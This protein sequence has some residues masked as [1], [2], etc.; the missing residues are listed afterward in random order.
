LVVNR[1]DKQLIFRKEESMAAK[2]LIRRRAD[3]EKSGQ[4]LSLIAR[5]RTLAMEQEGYVSGETLRSAADPDEYLVISSWNS[6]DD[7]RQW[8]ASPKR[9]EIQKQIDAILGKETTYEEFYFPERVP[10]NL[11]RFKGWEGG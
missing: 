5:L 9:D 3:R 4:I 7:W 2:I 1:Q 10:P 8:K 6:I 11:R